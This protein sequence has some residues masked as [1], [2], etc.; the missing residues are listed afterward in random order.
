ME[1]R[2]KVRHFHT[3][4]YAQVNFWCA[5]WE[6]RL[7]FTWQVSCKVRKSL[8]FGYWDNNKTILNSPKLGCKF[9]ISTNRFSEARRKKTENPS[10]NSIVPGS[11]FMYKPIPPR[12][13]NLGYIPC[14]TEW[15]RTLE[16]VYQSK[17]EAEK[18]LKEKRLS[19]DEERRGK[20]TGLKRILSHR[21]RPP[22]NPNK[23]H[24][25]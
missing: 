8:G 23:S 21:Y 6:K 19:Q 16:W 9:I 24:C 15:T 22:D 5:G 10:N 3:S 12:Y 18:D 20:M 13:R 1:K 4:S 25:Y 17:T 7:H 2:L 11:V 14:E